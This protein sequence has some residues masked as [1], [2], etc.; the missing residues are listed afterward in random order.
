[1]RSLQVDR[2][3]AARAEDAEGTSARPKRPR[4]HE[5]WRAKHWTVCSTHRRGRGT[6]HPQAKASQGTERVSRYSRQKTLT[7]L[8]RFLPEANAARA[9]TE[10]RNQAALGGCRR[11]KYSEHL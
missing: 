5:R 8:G 6:P 7:T 9:V 10:L 4:K 1:M 3:H 11:G 2:R